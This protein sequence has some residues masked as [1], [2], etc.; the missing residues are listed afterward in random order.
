M[1]NHNVIYYR[2]EPAGLAWSHVRSDILFQSVTIG[3]DGAVMLVSSEGVV[4]WRQGVSTQCPAG[5]AWVSLHSP[6]TKFRSVEAGRAGLLAL[7][8]ENK[9]WVRRGQYVQYRE[10]RNVVSR[11]IQ[12]NITLSENIVECPEL[13]G[14]GGQ[15]RAGQMQQ[16]LNGAQETKLA[17][18]DQ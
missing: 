16:S 11:V 18:G 15:C 2:D 4:T 7:D 13:W 14:V 3:P 5:L 9:L 6:G 12:C 8:T 1:K 10:V 17:T